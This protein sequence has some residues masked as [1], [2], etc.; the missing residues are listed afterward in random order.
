MTLG[1]YCLWIAIT[2]LW[3][4]ALI[5]VQIPFRR[6]NSLPTRIAILIIKLLLGLSVAFLIVA[7]YYEPLL[8]WT[9]PLA[10]LY[11]ALLGES[12][13]DLLQLAFVRPKNQNGNK[14]LIVFGLLC[15]AAYLIYGTVNMQTVTANHLSYSSSKLKEDYKIVFVADMHVGTSQS[16]RTTAKTIEKIND[17]KADFVLL[18]GDIV[19]VL[20][21]KNEMEETVNLI[22][23]IEAPVYFIYGN[24]DRQRDY[25]H[26]TKRKFTEEELKKAIE[27]NGIQILQDEWVSFSD[28][29]IIFGREDYSAKERKRIGEIEERPN[30][31]FVILVDHSPYQSS[32]IVASK[33]DLQLSGHS[34]AGQ[35]FPL[36]WLYLL[37]G[38]DAY[39][40]F[41]HGNT[42][43]YVSSGAS[44]WGFPFR[45]EEGCHYEVINLSTEWV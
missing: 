35:L 4:V 18:G 38:Y 36:K 28:D 10:G 8:K 29:L 39:G 6:K 42:D 27:S 3:T 19:D 1:G 45:T 7:K 31:K 26:E 20:T 13:G 14:L 11:V 33:A 43:L 22:G 17:E 30:D 34:H 32:D 16:M 24:H 9:F 25:S 15:T 12:A 23:E 37:T 5:G 21:T 2:A 41:R 40:W 44:G